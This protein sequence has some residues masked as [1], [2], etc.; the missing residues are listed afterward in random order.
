MPASQVTP[1]HTRHLLTLHPQH[2]GSVPNCLGRS[3]HGLGSPLST[4]HGSP[5]HTHTH[6]SQASLGW[7]RK[8]RYCTVWPRV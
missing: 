3:G 2:G 4:R 5:S 6:G 1:L 7:A 8:Q